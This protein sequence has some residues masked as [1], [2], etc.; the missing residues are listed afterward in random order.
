MQKKIFIPTI[1]GF[2]CFNIDEIIFLES[3]SNY[4]KIIFINKSELVSIP[5]K[6]F[7][8][9]LDNNFF[10]IHN[11]YIININ[12]LKGI[13]KGKTNKVK[14]T[15]NFILPISNSKKKYFYEYLKKMVKIFD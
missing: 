3:K 10:R 14:L 15:G 8:D 12:F 2:N 13:I 9:K 6:R 7:E 11:S 1:T 5:L 4:T